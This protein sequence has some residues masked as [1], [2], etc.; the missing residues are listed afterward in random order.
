MAGSAGGRT[1]S[2]SAFCPSAMSGSSWFLVI[3]RLA[4]SPAS[5]SLLPGL[6]SK[7]Y[8][9]PAVD[10]SSSRAATAVTSG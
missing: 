2:E 7:V 1:A 4:A 8:G 10:I 5:S 3:A 6:S 9:R